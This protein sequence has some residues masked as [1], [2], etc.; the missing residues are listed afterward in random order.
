M[1]VPSVLVVSV[2]A[3]ADPMVRIV[4]TLEAAFGANFS[5]A[6]VARSFAL[7][8][9][10]PAIAAKG[11]IKVITE[12]ASAFVVVVVF[13]TGT[14]R[15]VASFSRT[16]VSIIPSADVGPNPNAEP[17]TGARGRMKKL[18]LLPV[19]MLVSCST[20]T[21]NPAANARH[22]GMNAAGKQALAS[23]IPILGSIGTQVLLGAVQ[24][25]ATGRTVDFQQAAAAGLWS[26]APSTV[27]AIGDTI[28]A[29]SAGK[30]K[31]TAET[32]MSVANAAILQ[33]GASAPQA[34]NA[35]AQVI[36]AATSK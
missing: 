21:S 11:D 13:I 32:A 1:V 23:A 7:S 29:F 14:I 3:T 6:I 10:G 24:A 34:A 19:L 36:T 9:I 27:S 8:S 31:F 16:I 4:A 33:N 35:I 20:T 18:P 22:A 25:E 2:G 5:S 28:Q 17:L 30:A 26:Q 12:T 15:H